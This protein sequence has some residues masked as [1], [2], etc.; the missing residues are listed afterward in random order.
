MCMSCAALFALKRAIEE[1][2]K[3]TGVDNF[4]PLSKCA[5]LHAF[6]RNPDFADC[7]NVRKGA[8]IGNRY[9]QVPHLTQDTNVKVTNPQ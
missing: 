9:N 2:R 3:E 8:K 1:A 5:L 7:D 6:M 4:F